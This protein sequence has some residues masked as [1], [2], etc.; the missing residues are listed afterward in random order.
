[1]TEL[2]SP[3]AVWPNVEQFAAVGERIV[4]SIEDL[5]CSVVGFVPGVHRRR[6]DSHEDDYVLAGKATARS[7]DGSVHLLEAGAAIRISVGDEVWYEVDGRLLLLSIR[8]TNGSAWPMRSLV[9]GQN[10]ST[11]YALPGVVPELAS[12]QVTWLRVGPE[13]S[14]GFFSGFWTADRDVVYRKPFIADEFVLVLGG[15]MRLWNEAAECTVAAGDL[16][17]FRK[18]VDCWR[19]I[20]APYSQFFAGR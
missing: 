14:G 5:A 11:P 18:G 8:A 9:P 6:Q 1:M 10:P 17:L 2:V 20:T 16:A 15:A 4:G 13:G 19:A 3:F 12:S 7:G